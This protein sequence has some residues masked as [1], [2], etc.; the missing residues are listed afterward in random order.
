METARA[1]QKTALAFFAAGV[2]LFLTA[3]VQADTLT[4][5]RTP[6]SNAVAEISRRYGVNI[7][8]R[9]AVNSS[10]PV[11]FSVDNADT[12]DGRVQ[13]IN[14]L[15]NAL[16][17]DFQKVFIVSRIEPGTSV[18]E[19]KI[20]NDGPIVFP[21]TKVSAREAIQTIAGV[22]GA[23]TQISGAVKGS[24]VF[25]SRRM[26]AAR[27]AATVARQTETVW[28]AY[29]GFFKRGEEPARLKGD[30][31]G[32]DINGN[33]ITALPLV[34]FRNQISAP[35]TGLA[36][37][38]GTLAPGDT[39]VPSTGNVPG[40]GFSPYGDPGYG[41]YGNDYGSP[42]GYGGFGYPAPDGGVAYPGFNYS[43]GM[44]AGPVMPGVNAPGLFPPGSNVTTVPNSG[45][46]ILPDFPFTGGGY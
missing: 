39:F 42:Y 2:S 3:A 15:A 29:Y 14:D 9:S 28:R 13:A 20:D 31:V 10:K 6:A 32:R 24:V 22:D 18:P 12:P 45:I 40:F 27:A 37:D 26:T 5:T 44:G 35:T 1:G 36:S 41:S 23:V 38:G 25:P 8:F 4:F 17:M 30:V 33:P 11:T 16:D 7:I 34:T 43:P 21:T 46:T 19:V